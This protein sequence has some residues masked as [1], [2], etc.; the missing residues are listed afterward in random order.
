MRYRSVAGVAGRDARGDEH[1]RAL[2]EL[3]RFSRAHRRGG[4]AGKLERR[5]RGASGKPGKMALHRPLWDAVM[6]LLDQLVE[7]MG[8]QEPDSLLFAG[9]V[10][11]GLGAESGRSPFA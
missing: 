2:R 5:G 11:S 6:T 9:M 3:I 8:E 4:Y 10:D 7:L 1:K